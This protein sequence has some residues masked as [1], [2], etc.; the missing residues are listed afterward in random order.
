MV[1]DSHQ[2]QGR[3]TEFDLSRLCVFAKEMSPPTPTHLSGENSD[4]FKK[5][6]DCLPYVLGVSEMAKN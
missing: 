5:G 1:R 6:M 3:T 4:Q 2:D